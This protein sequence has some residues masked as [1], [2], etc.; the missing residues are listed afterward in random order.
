MNGSRR[1]VAGLL[2]ATLSQ[3]CTE[4]NPVGPAWSVVR[5]EGYWVLDDDLEGAPESLRINIDSLDLGEGSGV[6]YD[7]TL[8]TGSVGWPGGSCAATWKLGTPN[9]PKLPEIWVSCGGTSASGSLP[10]SLQAQGFAI[11]VYAASGDSGELERADPEDDWLFVVFDDREYRKDENWA[12]RYVRYVR[13][14]S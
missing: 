13:A 14:D 9:N 3:A 7:V 4:Y 8:A 5:S 12:A 2:L 11:G 6:A 10:R 1:F